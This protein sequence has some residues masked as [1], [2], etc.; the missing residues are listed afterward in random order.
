MP[1]KGIHMMLL[2]FSGWL[3]FSANAVAQSGNYVPAGGEAVNFGTI[4]LSTG[5]NWATARTAAPG[6]F[7]ANGT[8]S[9]TNGSAT[10]HV[11]G[12][13]KHYV[14]AA[15]QGFAFP[16]GSG[17]ALRTLTTSGTIANG[18]V[19]ATAWIAGD[20]TS[21]A[22]PTDASPGTHAVTSVGTGITAVSN[23]GQ[24]D[25][26]VS[27]GS[28][29]GVTVTVNIPDVTAFGPATDLRLVGWNGTQWV[30]L[31]GNTGASGNTAGST[32]AGTLISGI[33][34]LG[35]GKGVPPL[36]TDGDGVPDATD[37]DDDND[38]ITDSTEG[39]GDTDGDGL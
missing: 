23:V 11:N 3:L 25:W 32:L 13:V 2:W 22:D 7:A 31:S 37:Q 5:T 27:S 33:T 19:Y 38:G 12:Y 24:W 9:Y 16:V 30:N 34:A 35:I 28:A 17:T 26:L 10:N 21:T 1:T 15:N 6:F 8:A 18:S 14:R 29:A 20:P 36:D 4:D 39:T